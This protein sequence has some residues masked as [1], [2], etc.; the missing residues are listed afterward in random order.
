M[1]ILIGDKGNV[2]FDSAIPMT[3]HQQDLFIEF[4]KTIFN[5]VEKVEATSFRTDRIG[6][7]FFGRRWGDKKEMAMLLD[8][9]IKLEKVCELLGR[10]WMS[11]DIK[12]GEFVPELMMWADSKGY[13]L[14]DEDIEGLIEEYLNEKKEIAKEKKASHSSSEKKKNKLINKIK[15]LNKMLDAID[16]R[17]RSGM[18]FPS[19]EEKIK[20]TNEEIKDSEDELLQKYDV[21]CHYIDGEMWYIEGEED[22]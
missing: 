14:I 3:G 6:D 5:P 2:D 19:D 18:V 21:E 11:V 12:R 13:S 8:V 22:E 17:S 16:L 7:K 15:T 4:M 1:N 10:T 20:E 9:N